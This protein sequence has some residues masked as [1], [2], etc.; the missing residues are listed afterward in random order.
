MIITS[1]LFSQFFPNHSPTDKNKDL[2]NLN[3]QVSI[4]HQNSNIKAQI[5]NQI[6]ITNFFKSFFLMV[7]F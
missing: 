7:D 2:L 6:Q 5:T 4:K 3:F 1:P